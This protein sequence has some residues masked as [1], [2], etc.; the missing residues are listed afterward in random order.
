MCV[1]Q[2]CCHD[3]VVVAAGALFLFMR[4]GYCLLFVGYPALSQSHRISLHSSSVSWSIARL[5]RLTSLTVRFT[6]SKEM[7]TWY[8]SWMSATMVSSWFMLVGCCWMIRCTAALRAACGI[9]V[10]L[11]M[12]LFH[13]C[14]IVVIV[15][16]V[17][18]VCVP[19]EGDECLVCPLFHG[20]PRHTQSLGCHR[21]GLI[22]PVYFP[23]CRQPCQT[24]SL[25]GWLAGEGVVVD[26]QLQIDHGDD[27]VSVMLWRGWWGWHARLD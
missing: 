1:P 27:V 9:L 11:F 19:C 5:S 26:G 18:A 20:L 24:F 17:C 8:S 13:S 25:F 4:Y 22:I 7:W 6:S 21:I 3:R 14:S 23:E 12:V 2:R 16:V 15:W 10:V